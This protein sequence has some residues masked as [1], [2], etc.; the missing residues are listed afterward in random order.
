MLSKKIQ[1]KYKEIC[2]GKIIE[3]ELFR[4]PGGDP[5][6]SRNH[7]FALSLMIPLAAALGGC[8]DFAS[9]ETITNIALPPEKIASAWG[10]RLNPKNEVPSLGYRAIYFD[11]RAKDYVAFQETTSSI[12]VKFG[13]DSFHSIQPQS[14]SAYWVG[15]LKFDMPTEKQFSVSQ[16]WS[17]TRIYVDGKTVFDKSNEKKDF[18][19]NF[20]AGEHVIE[21]EHS[22]NW[23]TAEFKMTV[24]DKL[25]VLNSQSIAQ[26]FNNSQLRDAKIHY[27]NLYESSARDTSVKVDVASSS[28]PIVLWLNSYEAIDWKIAK[29]TN[30]VAIVISAYSPGS[31]VIGAGSAKI[32]GFQKRLVVS[33]S[34][35]EEQK[36]RSYAGILKGLTGLDLGGYAI[37]YSSSN[38]TTQKYVQSEPG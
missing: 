24:D 15:L 19:Y 25:K 34:G 27:I 2:Y 20:A 13:A 28:Q 29:G 8:Y 21:V 23:H 35:D 4:L 16:S 32:V 7:I 18:S 33:E 3:I 9:E 10:K 12:A 14:F 6:M 38:V 11:D 31:R 26:F 1:L 5:F 37:E 17:H 30:V 22:N 36:L